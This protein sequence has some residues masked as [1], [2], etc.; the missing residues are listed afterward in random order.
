MYVS[1]NTVAFYLRQIFR[2]LNVGSRVE[3]AR[4]VFQQTQAPGSPRPDAAT[5][6]NPGHGLHEFAVDQ[7]RDVCAT[8]PPQIGQPQLSVHKTR[9]RLA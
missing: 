4:I 8:F 6:G 3:L 7:R 9:V 2:K 5:Q 1:V